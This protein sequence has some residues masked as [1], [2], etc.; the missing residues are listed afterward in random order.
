MKK[1]KNH[2]NEIHRCQSPQNFHIASGHNKNSPTFSYILFE[3]IKKKGLKDSFSNAR[4]TKTAPAPKRMNESDHLMPSITARQCPPLGLPHSLANIST[5]AIQRDDLYGPLNDK[6]PR[7]LPI[8]TG[9]F[10]ILCASRGH[11]GRNDPALK[12]TAQ[13]FC[14]LGNCGWC[15]KSALRFF[16]VLFRNEFF[17]QFFFRRGWSLST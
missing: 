6:V 5:L 16:R 8:V 2:R 7:L 10:G 4:P 14:C 13:F 17:N 15:E 12:K 1:K 11:P 3:I 9:L